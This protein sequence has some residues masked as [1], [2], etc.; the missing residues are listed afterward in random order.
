MNDPLTLTTVITPVVAA[1][2][3][4][5]SA[6]RASPA[7]IGAVIGA[8]IALLTTYLTNR[9]HDK[10]QQTTLDADRLAKNQEREFGVKKEILLAF[11]DHLS[12]CLTN[13]SRLGDLRT[14][15][16]TI[17]EQYV[18]TSGVRGRLSIVAEDE[19]LTDSLELLSKMDQ[20]AGELHT[21]RLGIDKMQERIDDLKASRKEANEAHQNAIAK[22]RDALYANTATDGT[23]SVFKFEYE[24]IK[25]QINE[26]NERIYQDEVTLYHHA[27]DFQLMIASRRAEIDLLVPR[28]IVGLR[29]ALKMESDLEKFEALFKRLSDQQ[30]KSTSENTEELKRQ[31]KL[32]EAEYQKTLLQNE[33]I[34][35]TLEREQP[36]PK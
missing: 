23:R 32:A 18:A 31:Q 34:A 10:R 7:L 22:L 19:L 1:L 11:A 6:V 21:L 3:G 14:Q 12:V 9:A 35:K 36:Q 33:D 20:R 24:L 16:A 30:L 4:L 13:I 2:N 28:I 29:A 5:T 27:L 26:L 17:T 8:M 25:K 15:A